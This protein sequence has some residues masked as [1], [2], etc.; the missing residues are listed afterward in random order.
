MDFPIK[1]NM[2]ILKSTQRIVIHAGVLKSH[3]EIEG[4]M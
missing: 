1:C 2:F 4:N 3:Q